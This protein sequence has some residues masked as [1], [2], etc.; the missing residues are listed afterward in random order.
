MPDLC[1]PDD[2]SIV[3]NQAT[4]W[5]RRSKKARFM[6]KMSMTTDADTALDFSGGISVAFSDAAG[7]LEQVDFAAEDCVTK[8]RGR[9]IQ[10]RLADKTAKLLIL[11]DRQDTSNYA[12]KLKVTKRGFESAVVGPIGVRVTVGD[13][14]RTGQ[15]ANCTQRNAKTACK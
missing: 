6:A 4:A 2:D 15:N 1:D 3:V 12:M 8:A 13:L 10:C 11:Q 7:M 9:K 14:D 5:P